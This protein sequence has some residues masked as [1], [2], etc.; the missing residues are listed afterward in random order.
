MKL[1]HYSSKE[2]KLEPMIY[3]QSLSK[4]QAKPIGLWISVGDEWKKWCEAE[5]FNLE[6]CTHAHEVILK[7]NN[8]ILYLNTP[9]QIFAFGKKYPLRTGNRS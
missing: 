7:T 3:D 6:N 2:E 8:S 9:E 1:I 5:S 4:W